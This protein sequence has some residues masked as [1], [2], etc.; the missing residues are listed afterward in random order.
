[1]GTV[2]WEKRG[3][4]SYIYLKFGEASHDGRASRAACGLLRRHLPSPPPFFFRRRPCARLPPRASRGSRGPV[5]LRILL[6]DARDGSPCRGRN[7]MDPS[8]EHGL[9]GKRSGGREE[10][11]RGTAGRK[12]EAPRRGGHRD[13]AERQDTGAR[14]A[15]TGDD[16]RKER[17][18]RKAVTG[19]TGKRRRR[20]A[21]A[22]AQSRRSS[23]MPVFERVLSSTVLTITAQ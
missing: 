13:D 15:G 2:P 23:L 22:S 21:A 20:E 16:E 19:K 12:G 18:R 7:A 3:R 6:G 17:G 5:P 8:D 1:M 9:T 11:R 4:K 14:G 10:A